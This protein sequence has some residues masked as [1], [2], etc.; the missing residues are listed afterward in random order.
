M[1]E[2]KTFGFFFLQLIP[3]SIW[4]KFSLQTVFLVLM[5]NLS[6][7]ETETLRYRVSR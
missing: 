4:F 5:H 3:I 6:T 7:F 1:W 2:A